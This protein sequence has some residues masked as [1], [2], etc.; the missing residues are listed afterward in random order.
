MDSTDVPEEATDL[1]VVLIA[2]VAANGVIGA[3]GE[4]PWHYPEDLQHFKRTT[5]G[6]PVILGRRTFESITDRLGGPLPDR[7][8]IVL[9]RLMTDSTHEDVHVVSSPEAALSRAAEETDVR[10]VYV[11]GGASVYETVLPVA[12]R[13]HLTELEAAYEGDTTFPEWPPGDDWVERDHDE[14]EELNFIT[15]ERS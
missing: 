9:S 6:H 11:A 4:L 3:E 5:T 2:A 7:T 10:T 12:D 1:D 13:L 8:N 14:R 15:Y